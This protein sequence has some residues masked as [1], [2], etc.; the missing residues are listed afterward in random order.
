MNIFTICALS[1]EYEI[2]V[3]SHHTNCIM[4]ITGTDLT[5]TFVHNLQNLITHFGK[6]SQINVING[7]GSF[8]STRFS[9]LVT[10]T[11]GMLYK[12]PVKTASVI[13]C[14][15]HLMDVQQI[16]LPTGTMLFFVHSNIT[17][18]SQLTELIDYSLTYTTTIPALQTHAQ[19]SAF[20]NLLI[21]ANLACADKAANEDAQ[22]LYAITPSYLKGEW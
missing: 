21:G 11:L 13:E 14:V 10:K 22:P 18:N 9:V 12:I 15:N 17:Q 8:T 1:Q 2:G 7:P 16:I 5:S 20:P 19:Y 6:P 3:F 4:Q